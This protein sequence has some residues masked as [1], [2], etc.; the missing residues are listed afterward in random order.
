MKNKFTYLVCIFLAMIAIQGVAQQVVLQNSFKNDF[1]VVSN[2]YE[3]LEIKSRIHSFNLLEVNTTAG[4]FNELAIPGYGF[5]N[6]AGL[7]KVPVM[8]RIIE[9]PIG[10]TISVIVK[11]GNFKDYTLAELGI[12]HPVIP[13]QPPVS[14]QDDPQ[15]MPFSFNQDAYT[16]DAWLYDELVKVEKIGQMRAVRLARL[17]VYPIQYNPV[18]GKIRVYED[19]DVVVNFV[20]AQVSKTVDLKK[21][22]YSPYFEQAYRMTTNYQPLLTDELITDAPVTYVIVSDVMFQAALQPFIAWKTKKG[23]KVIEAYTNNPN[24]GNTTTS[25]KNYLQGLYNTPPTG[26]YPPSFVLFV[27][28]VAQIPAFNGTAGSHITDLYYCEYTGDKIPEVYWGRFS[29]SN[30]SQLQPQID[31]TLEYE[32]YLMPDP[33]F[34]NEVTMI[35]GADATYGP[36]HGNGQINY[37]TSNYFNAAHGLLSHTY[38]QPEP[39][40]ANYAQNIHTNVSN[41]VGYANYTAHCS[42][43]GWA[44]PSF[45]ISDIPPLQNQSKY[46]LMVGNCCQSSM[47]GGT[48]F[49]EEVLRAANKGALGYIGGT[50][51]SYWDEDFYWGCGFKTVS[52]SPVYDP[53]HLGAYDVTFHDQGEAQDDWFVTQGQ[54]V[55]GGNL[56]V[57]Q[58]NSSMKTYYWEMYCL[59]GD[60]SISIYFS[61]PSP[62][63][64]N[65][66]STLLVG[67]NALTVNTEE[68][69][70]VALSNNGVLLAT[71]FAGPTGV[72]NLN[73]DPINNVGTANLVVTKQNREPHIGNI[74]L[75]PATGPYLIV[76]SVA[77][78]DSLGNNNGLADYNE[79]VFLDVTFKN[80]GV[81]PATNVLAMLAPTDLYLQGNDTVCTIITFAA[82]AVLTVHN[83]FEVQVHNAVPDQHIANLVFEMTDGTNNWSTLQDLTLNAPVFSFSDI[84]ID[85]AAGNGNGILDP[86]ESANLIVNTTN[87]GHADAYNTIGNMVVAGGTSPY[88][89]INTPTVN[90]NTIA[91]G[92]TEQAVFN[93]ITNIITPP[94]TTVNLNYHVTAGQQNQYSYLEAKQVVIGA[95]A[96]VLMGNSTASTCNA[97]FYDSGGESAN[98]GVSEDYIMTFY[99]GISGA[100]VKYTFNSFSVE[101]NTSCT[102]DYLTV[103]NG[104]NTSAPQIGNYCGYSNPPS[105][106]ASNADGAITFKFRSDGVVTKAGWDATIGCVGGNLTVT[107][108]AF[109]P[110]I[111]DG[112]SSQLGTL[113]V[114]GTGNY[115][116]VWHPGKYLNDSTSATPVA[117]PESTTDFTV[118]VYD[119][120]TLLTSNTT[121]TVNP[122][123]VAP[124]ISLQ[125]STLVSSSVTGNQWYGQF[126]AIPGATGQMFTP[127]VSG[128]YFAR[129]SSTQGCL[130][131]SSNSIYVL[132]TGVKTEEATEFMQVFPNPF[133][134]DLTVSYGL[135]NETTVNISVF[136]AMGQ[137]IEILAD[138]VKNAPGT[139][140]LIFSAEGQPSGVYF[141]RFTTGKSV[142]LKRI[143]LTK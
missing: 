113:T 97:R 85:D 84:V 52:T 102:W 37:G 138:N 75:A 35:A 17:E 18:Q 104:V 141:I 133:K 55:V 59:M 78:N 30:L 140:T 87:T 107:A 91:Y 83:A 57:E 20:G 11:K 45:V 92:T 22:T 12:Q 136:N 58:S 77:V 99:P 67:M 94:L 130:S 34:L 76:Q 10:A 105:F 54:M 120:T 73:F 53:N 118:E 23:F 103:Y 142:I 43:S 114:G 86:G 115:T 47:F 121:V 29:A 4:T 88:L 135:K 39:G 134:K 82:G 25:I 124:V 137:E 123:P 119:G 44:D 95:T 143:L 1:G 96:S 101:Q 50:N 108:S 42:P 81:Q 122:I 36:L 116:Y 2:S 100:K 98:Y 49:A 65:Y 15:L 131:E 64:A 28:D 127:E 71:G 21:K 110:A 126:G 51:N 139:H 9:I 111:C 68:N 24:V 79:T 31:K 106:T 26:Y 27:G 7:P 56:A 112:N 129:V 13:A 93:V 128:E 89:I 3:N 60:P 63:V 32:Q 14:K 117:T 125:G 40:G 109:P 70:Y 6:E 132:I 19:I 48:C 72:V 5:S 41:G 33:S 74:T 16:K 80:V 62:V 90:I 38:L 8:K 46:C 66:Q 69:A 61:V